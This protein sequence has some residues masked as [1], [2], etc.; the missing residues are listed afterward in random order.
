[1]SYGELRVSENPDVL[2]HDAATL[3]CDLALANT[4]TVR[5]A[6]SGGSTPRRTY[7]TLASAPF[8]QRFPWQRVEWFWG[9]ERFV[10][11]D[12]KDSNL[13]MTR[14][15]ML[16]HAPVPPQNVHPMPT[17]GLTAEQ[18][19]RTYEAT[20][21]TSYGADT[22]DPA[23]PLFDLCLLGLGD[24]GHTASLLPGEPVLE[25]HTHWVAEVGHGRPEVRI[26][27]TYPVIDNAGVIAFLVSGAGK[28]E[29]LATVLS[30]HSDVPAARLQPAGKLLFLADQAAGG[31]GR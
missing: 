1:M 20:L 14:E 4:G 10:P 31:Q 7:Q 26:T 27:I 18:A 9:D 3:M 6:L 5:V 15:A 19:A 2:A 8:L 11:P 13:R 25:E 22:L 21:R 23:R 12:H 30:G 17:V 16:S 28:R 24:D 29:I